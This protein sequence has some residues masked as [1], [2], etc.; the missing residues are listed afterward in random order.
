[1][2][3]FVKGLHFIFAASL[4]VFHLGWGSRLCAQTL[5]GNEILE[6]VDKNI[7]SKTRVF[8]SKM[9]IH[10]RRGSRTVVSK[11]WAEGEDKTFT[12]YLAPA[13]EKG[14]KML[15]LEDKL[16]MYSPSTD[17][18]IQISGHMLRQSV[19][20]SDLSYED[21]MEDKKLT[22][23]YDAM[24]IGTETLDGVQCWILDLTATTRDI[25]YYRRKLWV[26]RSRAIPLREELYAKGGKL[27][28]RLELKDVERIQDRWFPKRMIFKDVLKKGKGTEFIME[29][30][31]FDEA[32]PE[33]IFSKAS[34]R[35]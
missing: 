6:Q 25:A 10:G 20:G 8:T 23:H 15:K 31:L 17:R 33:H 4:F 7:S 2:K 24:V 1:M 22:T 12:E 11:S 3:T 34:L 5:S 30:I 18:T 16:W 26:D 13:R 21:M 29:D 27:L 19:M 9:V 35:Q 28:K 14:T 32:I